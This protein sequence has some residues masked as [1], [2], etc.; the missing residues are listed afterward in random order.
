M[1]ELAQEMLETDLQLATSADPVMNLNNLRE[2]GF[3]DFLVLHRIAP[4]IF[5]LAADSKLLQSKQP[6][7]SKLA[8]KFHLSDH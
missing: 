6:S 8:D 3:C 7:R 1:A 2:I 5:M 4:K